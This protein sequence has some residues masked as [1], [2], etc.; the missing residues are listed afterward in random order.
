[1][2]RS[3]FPRFSAA[4]LALAAVSLTLQAQ[5]TNRN[6]NNNNNNRRNTQSNTG[7]RSGGQGRTGGDRQYQN[8]TMLG[9]ATITSNAE[10]RR[11]IVV[12][13]DE[14]NE[15][16]KQ[17]I[18]S[19]DRPK[20]QVLI[21]VVFLQ[22]THNKD[23]DL[24]TELSHMGSELGNNLTSTAT[25]LFGAPQTGGFYNLVNTDINATIHALSK[26]G[27]TEILSRPSI[28]ARSSQQATIM[29]G[30]EVPFITNSRISDTG[31]TTNTVQYQDIGIILRVTPFITSEGL[32]EM[33]VTPEIS[34]LSDRTVAIS[35][36]VNT[37]VI[38]KRSADTVVVTPSD[39]TV[40]IGGLIS[41]QTTNTDSKVPLL[42]DIPILGHAFKRTI[43]QNNKTELLIFLTP[44]VV[45]HPEDLSKLTEQEQDKLE[46]KPT[47]FKSEDVN[48]YLSKP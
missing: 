44:H 43:K 22:V 29:V 46:L 35:D 36:T 31:Q 12:T 4:C 28:L 3:L 37:P 34:A 33:I 25:T 8:S 39:R 18:E 47:T 42:G 5:T 32:V 14:T 40:V 27:K 21:N 23:L 10:T 26:V 38:D 41:N 48:K 16:I 17:V 9:D 45:Q 13:D 6:S 20:P 2:K 19:L 1:M 30:Q 24:G 7:N 15:N 11:I